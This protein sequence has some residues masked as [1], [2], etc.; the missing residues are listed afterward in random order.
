MARIT[1]VLPYAGFRP[2]DRAGLWAIGGAGSGTLETDRGDRGRES[3]DLSRRMGMVGMRLR[4]SGSGEGP[5]VALRGAAGV[6]PAEHRLRRGRLRRDRSV[7]VPAAGGGGS[8]LPAESGRRARVR[9]ARGGVGADGRR[10]GSDRG[11]L[12]G[13]G[14]PADDGRNAVP[15]GGAGAVA[16][17]AR[18]DGF[19]D[20]AACHN[21]PS[22][23][24]RMGPS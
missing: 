19:R 21:G 17:G 8:P 22:S 23:Q 14:R 11:W 24:R 3:R 4:V 1:G 13:V 2:T 7:G 10:Y 15:A 16:G 6:G 5:G 18:R 12:G 20:R 9:A